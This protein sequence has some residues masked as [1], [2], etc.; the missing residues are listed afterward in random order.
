M[1]EHLI[2][3]LLTCPIVKKG[4]Y[5]YFV[6]PITDGVPVL[7][8]ALLREVAVGMIRAMDLTKIDYIVAAEAMGIPIGSSISLMTDIPLNIIRKREY[9]LPGEVEVKQQTGYSHGA[10]FINGLQKGDR[11]VI[12]DDVISTGGTIRGIL[13]AMNEIGTDVRD[14]CFAIKK[15][16]ISLDVPFKYLV[17]IEVTDKVKIV[18]NRL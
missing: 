13:K 4:E 12:V 2:N 8:A 5:N 7:D 3:S 16:E 10:M 18:E 6:H 15:G 9:G 17:A 14:I 11:V 1:Q